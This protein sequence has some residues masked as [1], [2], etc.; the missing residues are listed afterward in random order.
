LN[1]GAAFQAL[2][3][4]GAGVAASA[5]LVAPASAQDYTNVTASG[6]VQGTNRKAIAGATVEFKSEDQGFTR[7]ATTDG[8][9]GYAVPQLKP[10]IYTITVSASGHETLTESGVAINQSAAANQFTLD[11]S[12]TG[13]EI[14]VTAGRIKVVDFDRNTTGAVINVAELAQNVPI[15]RTITDVALLSPGAVQGGATATFGNLPS[16]NGASVSENVYYINGLNITQFRNG[17]GAVTV[18]F[19]FYQSVEVKNGGISA[20][21]GRTT[22]GVINAVTKSGTNEFHGS[23]G[24]N[25][26]PDWGRA[27]APKTYLRDYDSRYDENREMIAQ[28]SGPV[29]KDHVFLYGI[30]VDRSLK[31]NL[32][33]TNTIANTNA[34]CTATVSQCETFANLSA[35][36]LNLAGTQYRKDATNSPFYGGKLDVVVIDGQRLEATYF[37]TSN[38][39]NRTI[40]GTAAS[41]LR[42]NPITNAPGNYA[43]TELR[44]DGGENYV[45]RYT[46]TFTDWFT[47]SGAYGV[48]KNK[49]TVETTTPG[50]SSI[51]D[52]RGG[53]NTNIGNPTANKT[54]NYDKR[55]FYRADAD[56]NFEMVGSHHIRFGYDREDLDLDYSVSANGGAQYTLSTA[57]GTGTDTV[58]GLPTGTN[59]VLRRTFVSGGKFGT[60]NTAFYVQDSWKLF[61]DRLQLN[62]GIRN[63]KF[64]NSNAA[65]IPFYKSGGQWGPRLGFSFDPFGDRSTKVYGSFSRYFLPIAANTNARLAGAELDYDAYFRFGSLAADNTPVVGAAVTTGAGFVTCPTGGPSGTACVLRNDGTVG[66]T[67]SLVASN[68]KPQSTDEFILGVERR[69]GN[70]MKVGVFFTRNKLNDSLED[71]SLDNAIVD[72][73][74]TQGNN[75]AACNGIWG[76]VHQYALINPGRDVAITLSDLLPNQAATASPKAVLLSAAKLGYPQA[77][78][79]YT[80]F[81]LTFDREFD[82]KWGLS[83]NYTYSKLKGNI[84]GGIRTDNAQT[85][86]GLTTA[87]DLPALVNGSYG[88]LPNDRRHNFKLYGTYRVNDWLQLGANAQLTA[89]RHFGCLGRAP[90]QVDGTAAAVGGFAGR[91]YGTGGYYCNVVGGAVVTNPVGFTLVNPAFGAA[92]TSTL[93]PTPR[94]S[95]FASD[96][97]SFVNLDATFRL[98]TDSFDASLRFSVI[99]AFNQHNRTEYNEVGTA[100]AGTPNATYGLPNIIQ[101][102]RT[103]RVQLKIGF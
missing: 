32:G 95:Q 76:G 39:L 35:A 48:N 11:V 18:P 24:M 69:I 7:T 96:W 85:D 21:F 98:P 9:G 33:F 78:R 53:V 80:A 28:L 97:L 41:G 91:F 58:T 77:T 72:F 2:A 42:Y 49:E 10:G 30:Y 23:V 59:Y 93:Q 25:W 26:E 16:I 71:S 38:T 17:L 94:G 101:Q 55:T 44:R 70:G 68:L 4:V 40:F 88:Y 66:D 82:G 81:T 50:L 13:D 100:T 14:I 64:V 65:G 54:L 90:A 103:L 29:I 5:A 19:D 83:A 1:S 102:P 56:L 6:K 74:I 31:T 99:N 37:N 43:S 36:N 34:I 67:D 73:C 92:G 84:E 12:G 15:G 20:E 27:K 86:S 75:A 87:F 79:T 46:G 8:A 3:I 52:Q 57:G 61:D 45:L 51:I 60:R 22:G 62:L 47:L 63:D 89:P